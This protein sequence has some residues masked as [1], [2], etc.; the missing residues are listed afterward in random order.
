LPCLALPCLALPCLNNNSERKVD[1]LPP[2]GLELVNFSTLA[3][4][5]ILW[6]VYRLA[7]QMMEVN[8]HAV[9][10][11]VCMGYYSLNSINKHNERLVRTVYCAQKVGGFVCVCV[12]VCVVFFVGFF[13]F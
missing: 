7:Q 3:H 13:F 5:S 6:C 10:P 11:W 4:L 1:S 8:E 2:L 9:E 12:C